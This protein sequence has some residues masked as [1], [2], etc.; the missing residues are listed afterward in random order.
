MKKFF[1]T[2]RYLLEY[3][4]VLI[5][6]KIFEMLGINTATNVGRYLARKIGPLLP[7][8]KVVKENIQNVF[9]ANID[10]KILLTQIWDNFGSFIGEFPYINKM[11]EEEVIKRVEI[12]GESNIEKFRQLHQPFLLFTGHFA[13]WDIVLK[14]AYKFYHK[15]VVIYRKANNPYVDKLINNARRYSKVKFI[16]KG[17]TGIR[18]LI[19]AIKSGYSIGMLIDQK[20]ND[21]IEVPLLG[22]PAMTADSIAKLALQFN[23]PIVPV[24]IVRTK[25]SYFKMIIHPPIEFQKTIDNKKDCYNIMCTI[26]T[27]L[28]DW[29]KENPGQWFWFHNR[30][31]KHKKSINKTY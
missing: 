18:E 11:S 2:T 4:G 28:G 26:N 25:G 8:N 30:W 17:T 23:Y 15:C 7:V 19:S 27:M 3:F 31:K 24:Q 16:P 22:R 12:I 13:N 1:K 10:S 9:G 5:I 21:G 29:I 14:M 20:M 6:I